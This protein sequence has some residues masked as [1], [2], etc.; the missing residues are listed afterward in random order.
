LL[1]SIGLRLAIKSD[2]SQLVDLMNS[3]Y[4]RKKDEAYFIW[5]YFDS[6]YPTILICAFS[7]SKII[8]MFGL[9][10]RKLRDDTHVGQAIDLLVAHEWR[11]KGIFKLLGEKAT[12]YFEDLD[13]LCVLPNVNGKNACEKA[14]GWKTVCKVNSMS[15]DVKSFENPAWK[16]PKKLIENRKAIKGFYYNAEIRRWRYNHHPEYKYVYVALNSGEFAVTKIF[17]EPVTGVLYGDI[18]DFECNLNDMYC[19][20]ELFFRASTYLKGEKV[21]SIVTWALPHIPL[22][23]VLKSI[24]FTELPQE[25]Y[26]CVKVL[27]KRYDYLYYIS[28]WHLVQA[29][30]EMY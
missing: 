27:N 3:Q 5:Q 13:L 18:V 4:D 17:K 9:Q 2:I 1:G 7:A 14:L 29:D 24:G 11:K 23:E 12:E 22:C 16:P 28:Q 20:R 30:A 6:S 21:E 19:L 26:F 15:L 25:R 8:G 10:K